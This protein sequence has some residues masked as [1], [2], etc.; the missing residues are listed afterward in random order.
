[1]RDEGIGNRQDRH[2]VD[3]LID[4]NIPGEPVKLLGVR[5]HGEDDLPVGPA[6]DMDAVPVEFP[7]LVHRAHGDVH[8][9]LRRFQHRLGHRPDRRADKVIPVRKGVG[10][11]LEEL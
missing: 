4:L 3:G 7:V 1:M 10:A 2:L 11:G 8:G 9:F 6:Q 5:P